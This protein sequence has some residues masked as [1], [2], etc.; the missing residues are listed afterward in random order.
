MPRS[1]L[2]K[3]GNVIIYGTYPNSCQKFSIHLVT[4][5]E[6]PIIDLANPLLVNAS[7]NTAEFSL[8]DDAE[9]EMG[10]TEGTKWQLNILDNNGNKIYGSSYSN[11][12]KC[13]NTSGW[14]NGL[15]IATAKIGDKYYSVKF[16][17]TR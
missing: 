17:I 6:G 4:L 8:H 9:Q 14:K 1:G 3:G 16:S 11:G 2:K 5:Y 12:S 15:Y 10:L 7:G 13:V